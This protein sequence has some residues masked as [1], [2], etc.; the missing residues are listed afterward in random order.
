MSDFIKKSVTINSEFVPIPETHILSYKDTFLLS[1][2]N[3]MTIVALSGTGKSH[4]S[5]YFACLFCNPKLSTSFQMSTLSGRCLVIDTERNL[6]DCYNGYM[7]MCKRLENKQEYI[8]KFI[9]ESCILVPSPEERIEHIENLI[10]SYK[11]IDLIVIDGL[12]DL[13]HNPNDQAESINMVEKLMYTINKHNVGLICTIHGNRG[14]RSG[15]GKGHIGD[16]CQR[17]SSAFL[18]LYRNTSQNS[19]TLTSDFEN[20]KLRNGYDGAINVTFKW[21]SITEMFEEG[22][23]FITPTN[24]IKK[25]IIN[26]DYLSTIFKDV[27]ILSHKDLTKAYMEQL[28]CSDRTARR[29]IEN[30]LKNL[31]VIKT[32]KGY[33]KSP[34]E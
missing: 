13:I 26:T 11:D 22:S 34:N 15:K 16:A 4:I 14:D 5:E 27:T 19:S 10:I 9:F 29:K 1:K 31:T 23:E 12:L 28:E 32:D 21:N 33:I 6:N 24:K 20:N 3:M 7:R 25:D 30:D 2:G 18:R 8:D 17:K